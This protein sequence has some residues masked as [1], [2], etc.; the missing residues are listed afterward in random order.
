MS[1]FLLA[2]SL[3]TSLDGYGLASCT[4]RAGKLPIKRANC[5]RCLWFPEQIAESSCKLHDEAK[6]LIRT[7]V[8]REANSPQVES[9]KAAPPWVLAPT[10]TL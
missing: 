5:H 10:E 8:G 1:G 4:A 6:F 7:P 9:G 2:T 3:A